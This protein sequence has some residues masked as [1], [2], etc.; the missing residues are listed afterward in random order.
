MKGR[1]NRDGK[2][3]V[4]TVKQRVQN[5]QCSLSS[6]SK[7]AKVENEEQK[8]INYRTHGKTLMPSP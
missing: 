2:R 1:T 5:F 3:I 6:K 8:K 4:E 7:I